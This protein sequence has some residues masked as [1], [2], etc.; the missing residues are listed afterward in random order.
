MLGRFSILSI[1]R[2][3]HWPTWYLLTPSA[4]AS[5][6]WQK[7]SRLVLPLNCLQGAVRPP[8]NRVQFVCVQRCRS[9]VKI[10]PSSAAR[11]AHWCIVSP[12]AAAAS[13]QRPPVAIGALAFHD[14]LI[15]IPQTL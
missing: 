9:R 10:N 13:A 8:F 4:A 7:P 12:V 5:S 2:S 11:L 3:R 15:E 14:H 6:S 1:R